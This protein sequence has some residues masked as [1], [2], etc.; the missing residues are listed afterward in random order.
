MKHIFKALLACS[1]ILAISCSNNDEGSGDELSFNPEDYHYFISGKINGESFLYGQRKDATTVDYNIIH[2][3]GTTTECAYYPETGGVNYYSGV[4]PNF[5][6]ETLPSMNFGFV[7]FYL[8]SEMDATSQSAVFNERFA[9]GNYEIATKDDISGTTGGI[10]F[11]YSSNSL[12][13]PYYNSNGDQSSSYCEITSST[14]ANQYLLE[15]LVNSQQIIEGN[16]SVKLYNEEDSSD[17]IEI[18]DGSFKLRP[19]I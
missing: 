8:C 5:E 4:Y 7:R 16:F 3:G 9:L 15:V 19:R 11:E 10:Y 18:T 17:V 2:S 12:E 6:E 1:I 14:N 13:G